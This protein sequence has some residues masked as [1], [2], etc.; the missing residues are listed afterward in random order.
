V[1]RAGLQISLFDVSNPSSPVLVDR[2]S[3]GSG[4]NSSAEYDSH[5]VSYFAD[6]G[7][8]TLPVGNN[9]AVFHVDPT[10]GFQLIGGVLHDTPVI[11]SVQINGNLYSVAW[12]SVKVQSLQ[13]PG[14]TI[15]E[16]HLPAPVYGLPIRIIN[17]DPLPVVWLPIALPPI[18]IVPLPGDPY[19][20]F[21][22][23]GQAEAVA[24]AHSE[25]APGSF[26]V[27]GS[28]SSQPASPGAHP[29]NQDANEGEK[30]S[31]DTGLIDQTAGIPCSGFSTLKNASG[32][33]SI[34]QKQPRAMVDDMNDL[35]S[36][37]Q[38]VGS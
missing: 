30:P 32:D 22:D 6:T 7:I 24:P 10:I 21:P 37:A 4:T 12:D 26:L 38:D 5:A 3:F 33:G 16:V 35:S 2:Y 20:G 8:L 27:P 1:V 29:D 36:I 15:G 18:T 17:V 25:H 9:L 19:S 31:S 34:R 28:D 23:D 13:Q 11:E 14:N